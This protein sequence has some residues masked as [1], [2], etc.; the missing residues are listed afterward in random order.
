MKR[1]D[2]NDLMVTPRYLQARLRGRL[3]DSRFVFAKDLTYPR[4][5]RQMN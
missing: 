1:L 5:R 4:W 3:E 2:L